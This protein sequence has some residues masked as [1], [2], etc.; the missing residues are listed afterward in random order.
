M[1]KG[2]RKRAETETEAPKRKGR[3]PGTGA[4]RDGVARLAKLSLRVSDAELA[5]L[6]AHAEREGLPVAALVVRALK[7]AGLLE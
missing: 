7:R 5:A 4:L 2:R 6:S 3:P 1:A